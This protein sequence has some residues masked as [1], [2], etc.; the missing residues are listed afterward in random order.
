MMYPILGCS[1]HDTFF[2]PF[3]NIF[4]WVSFSQASSTDKLLSH[5]IAT[6]SLTPALICSS[7]RRSLRCLT[8]A[9]KQVYSD[10]PVPIHDSSLRAIFFYYLP[11]SPPLKPRT[12]TYWQ[13][14]VSGPIEGDCL[15]D[16]QGTLYQRDPIV[17]WLVCHWLPKLNVSTVFISGPCVN[18]SLRKHLLSIYDTPS[19]LQTPSDRHLLSSQPHF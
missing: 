6:V 13:S 18:Q 16:F 5:I 2:F 10:I 19:T 3:A 14:P 9:T 12:F 11:L 7:S 17:M 15:S 4:T 8:C 1:V